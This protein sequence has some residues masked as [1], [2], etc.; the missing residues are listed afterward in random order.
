MY[1]NADMGPN[2]KP[3]EE[4]TNRMEGK[5]EQ[6]AIQATSNI[7]EHTGASIC[8]RFRKPVFST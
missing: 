7:S 3:D 6:H 2:L 4:H 1:L 5:G 8:K